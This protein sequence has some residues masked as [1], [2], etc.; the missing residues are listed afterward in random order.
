MVARSITLMKKVILALSLFASSLSAASWEV[1]AGPHFNYTNI[2][3]N[4][5]TELK[6]Y[7][8]GVTAGIDFSCCYFFSNV[9][10]EGTWNAGPIVGTP[11]QRSDLAEYFV[12]LK[13][14]GNFCFCCEKLWFQPYTGFG[15]DRFEN[16]QDPKTAALCYRYDKLFIPVGFYLDWLFCNCNTWGIQFEWRPDVYS[17][18]NLLKIDLKNRCEQA[19][20]VQSPIRFNYDC[21]C[22]GRFW[23]EVVPFFDWTQYGAVNEKNSDGVSLPIPSLKRWDLGLRLLFGW[24]Y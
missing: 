23:T 6:G 13:L 22:C 4:N 9:E 8:A 12:E 7:S 24:D 14:G 11:C 15:W 5:P 18:L 10:F 20:R 16:E 3:F 17:C 1:Y 21:F 19:F 2:E